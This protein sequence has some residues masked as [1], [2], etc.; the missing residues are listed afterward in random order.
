M[1]G[2]RAGLSRD[3]GTVNDHTVHHLKIALQQRLS[4]KAVT[5]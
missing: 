3:A 4:H 1:R 2:K 5:S